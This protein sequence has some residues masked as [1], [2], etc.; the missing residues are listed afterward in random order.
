MARAAA[1]ADRR[2]GDAIDA[3][4]HAATG[5]QGAPG[6]GGMCN[7]RISA[8][9]SARS[10][11]LV[12]QNFA[13]PPP[14][15]PVHWPALDGLRA[16]AVLLVLY[17]HAPPLLFGDGGRGIWHGSR[18]AWLGV[19]LFFVLSG[20]LIT[21]ILLQAHGRPGALR[22]F[23]LRR[24]LRIFPLA[25]AYLVTLAVVT[26]L[27][28]G[29]LHLR[30]ASAFG[31][32]AVY[33]INFHIA[34][35]GW[36]ATAFS[37]L[38]SLAV[39]EHFYLVWPFVVLHLPRRLVVVVVLALVALAPLLRAVELSR[40]GAVGVYVTT[41][42]RCDT[43]AWGALLAIGWH[44]AVRERLRRLAGWLLVPSLACVGWV[45]VTPLPP[46]GPLTPEWF[47]VGGYSAIAASFTV[48]CAFAVEP[49][50]WLQHALGNAVLGRIGR[51]SYGLYVWHV[52]TAELT[53]RGLAR[54][55]LEACEPL[56][57]ITWLV[58]LFATA[59]L[60]HRWLE[61]PLL[62]LKDRIA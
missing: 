35:H 55:H 44:G 12:N 22:R 23:W 47:H 20:F 10:G 17:N 31:V 38:W 15:A 60:S 21:S 29:F 19:D 27:V 3:A 6:S 7:R 25:Y 40:L 33:L 51:I 59:S 37:L 52:L 9:T 42:C 36:P 57:V 41:H 49:P 34:T 54:L 58:L 43:L 56:L 18:G 30:D 26:W 11:N 61:A 28:P 45:L 32:A 16:L 39:E 46:L 50:P 62:R 4:G 2:H 14:S 24:A 13:L 48:W 8:I 5:A 1:R 53:V